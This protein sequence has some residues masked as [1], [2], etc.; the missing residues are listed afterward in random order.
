MA[1][2]EL[3]TLTQYFDDAEDATFQARLTSETCDYLA[4][5]PMKGKVDCLNVSVATGVCLYEALRQ[6]SIQA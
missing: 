4:T 3:Q 1:K 2:I 6:R 5:I